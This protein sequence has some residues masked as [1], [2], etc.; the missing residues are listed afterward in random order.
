M[1][2]SAKL[3]A[4]MITGSPN[5][6]SKHIECYHY[7]LITSHT[8]KILQLKCNMMF[9]SDRFI[10]LTTANIFKIDLINDST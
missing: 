4:A 9:H 5:I 1:F 7:D 2:S 3:H 10:L 8:Q 6:R